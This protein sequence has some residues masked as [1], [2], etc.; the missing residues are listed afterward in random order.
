MIQWA[1][2]KIC[3]EEEEEEEENPPL[4]KKNKKGSFG[5]SLRIG[6]LAFTD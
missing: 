2:Q 4:K 1:L 6:N 3:K 5:G